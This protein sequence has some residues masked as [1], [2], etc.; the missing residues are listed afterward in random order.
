MKTYTIINSN[1]ERLT[2]EDQSCAGNDEIFNTINDLIMSRTPFSV[3][4]KSEAT[5]ALPKTF[6]ELIDDINREQR[7]DSSYVLRMQIASAVSGNVSLK[8]MTSKQINELCGR[9]YKCLIECDDDWPDIDEVAY[10][11]QRL[12]DDGEYDEPNDECVAQAFE[13]SRQ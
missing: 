10:R 1:D 12:L 3:E 8:E 5:K 4:F 6:A 11:I 13:D 7:A 9:V 2:I